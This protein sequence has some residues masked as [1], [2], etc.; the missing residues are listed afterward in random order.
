M[1]KI[2]LVD[3]YLFEH[4]QNSPTSMLFLCI[5]EQGRCHFLPFI[6]EKTSMRLC[7]LSKLMQGRVLHISLPPAHL[8]R[9]PP[10]LLW[11]PTVWSMWPVSHRFAHSLA[12]PQGSIQ[13]LLS[14]LK[15]PKVA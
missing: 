4:L 7:N 2:F 9:D 8:P 15:G 14:S 6:S 3:S 10:P 13:P 5:K 12:L 1:T 11:V